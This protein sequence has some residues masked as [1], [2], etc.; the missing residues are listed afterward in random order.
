MQYQ[1]IVFHQAGQAFRFDPPDGRPASD[2]PPVVRVFRDDREVRATAGP[3]T[4]DPVDTRLHGDAMAG[5]RAL[6]VACVDGIVVGGRYAMTRPD[7]AREWI[8]VV[9]IDGAR[10]VVKHP[11]I[12]RYAGNATIVGC[13]LS[14][15]VDPGWV[16]RA[17]HLTDLPER[18][19]GLAGYV[20]RWTYTAGS[21]EVE[22][23]SYADLV[24]CPAAEL[25]TARDVEQRFPGWLDDVPREQRATRGADFI[26]EAFRV[27]RTEAIGD[28]H[29]QRKIRDTEVLRELVNLRA[30]VIRLEDD[31]LHGRGG[32]PELARAEDQYRSSYARL[33]QHRQHQRRRVITEAPPVVEA[34]ARRPARREPGMPRKIPKLTKL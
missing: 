22:G 28:A 26:A 30:H 5:H 3:C 2:P 19:H 12:H 8:E 24:S 33:M 14:A 13:R 27:V 23:I 9:A 18:A 17:D 31:V 32:A 1:E 7:G 16:A 6:R 10:L 15:A 11:L 34:P 4:I 20:L 29:A 25:V 21:F